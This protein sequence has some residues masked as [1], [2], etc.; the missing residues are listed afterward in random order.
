MKLALLWQDKPPN[1]LR[2]IVLAHRWSP[3]RCNCAGSHLHH[4]QCWHGDKDRTQKQSWWIL[5]H[6]S[7][8]RNRP[9]SLLP[10]SPP[11]PQKTLPGEQIWGSAALPVCTVFGKGINRHMELAIVGRKS[12]SLK[13]SDAGKREKCE[14]K[15]MQKVDSEWSRSQ[16][17]RT[18]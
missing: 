2:A 1:I 14:I 8:M 9:T 11:C 13:K 18:F 4:W 3:P 16:D 12:Q 15:K 7:H 17:C 6:Q 10:L 5:L